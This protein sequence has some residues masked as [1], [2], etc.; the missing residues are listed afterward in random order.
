MLENS[1]FTPVRCGAVFDKSESK[2]QGDDTGDNISEKRLS[3]CELTTQY[4]AWKNIKAD[5][6]GFCHYRRYF[7]FNPKKLDTDDWNSVLRHYFNDATQ[8]EL[9]MDENNIHNVVE[10][11]DI[12]TPT[13]INLKWVGIKSVYEQY[14]T[15]AQ[16]HVQDLN[17]VLDVIGDLYPDYYTTAQEYLYG[18]TLYLCNMFIMKKEL[19]Q[20]YSQWLFDILFEF[21]KRA[22]MSL[23]SEEG[24]RTPGHLGERLFGIYCTYLQ[25]QQR[26]KFGMLQIV[27]IRDPSPVQ[28]L[29][30]AF[31][32]GSVGIA[33]SSSEN[34]APFC[35]TA[36]KSIIDNSNSKRNY[37]I[38]IMESDIHEKVKILIKKMAESRPN[39]SIRFLNVEQ[40]I[41]KYRLRIREHFTVQT[42]F[43]L[44]IPDLLPDYEKV[45]YLDCDLII[46]ADVSELFDTN[47]QE[48]YI[49]GVP[50]TVLAGILNGYDKSKN[51]YYKNQVRIKEENMLTQLNAGVLLMNLAAIRAEYSADEMLE[52]A[53]AGAFEL[54]DQ[55]VLN[56]L[57]QDSIML[58]S[59]E[60]N[61]ADDEQGTLR[62]Y[63]ATF[64]PRELFHQYSAA[65]KNPKIIHYLG[66]IK[67]WNEPG[68][69]LADEFW[70]TLIETPFYEIVLHRRIVEN[71]Q[72]FSRARGDAAP[73]PKSSTVKEHRLLPRRIGDMLFPKGSVRREN[74]K[75]FLCKIM[76]KQYVE[77]YYPVG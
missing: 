33:M 74:I 27:V 48:Y 21:E 61:A 6:Y 73:A 38:I 66:T 20:S 39:I 70:N 14:K 49:A 47:I 65:L 50:D 54:A 72:Y 30:P 11:F 75:K 68:Y 44:L 58:L 40:R 76:G 59:H 45:L 51:T 62:A 23:Y 24:F 77:P 8:K 55:D 67:P 64:A 56:S 17:L 52:Y 71:V 9:C 36:I 10:R 31:D 26:F 19:F 1:I 37:D 32:Q 46:K 16:L 29:K 2:I 4:W 15:G 12:L 43:R 18:T 42:Y 60:W 41:S 35:A 28:T 63:V 3:Y 57:F 34:F 25:K 13:P 7:S 5:Y 69:Q 53:Q 22:D